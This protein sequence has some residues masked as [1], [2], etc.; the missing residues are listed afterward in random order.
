MGGL[1]KKY[2]LEAELAYRFHINPFALLPAQR[3]GLMT[4]LGRFEAQ[5]AIRNGTFNKSDYETVY[6]LYICA[7]DDEQLAAQRRL[8]AMQRLVKESCGHGQ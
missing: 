3:A 6:N 1:K 4:N 5:D 7:Y 8:E 2:R